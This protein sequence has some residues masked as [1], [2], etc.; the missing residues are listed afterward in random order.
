MLRLLQGDVGSGKT[1]VALLAMLNAV[2][3]GAQAAIMAPTE[4]LAKQH[5]DSI[6]PLTEKIGVK[7][8]LLTG[9]TKGKARKE[10][11]AELQN[12]KID[13]LVGTH[14]LFTEDV[15]FAD[16]ACA[17]IDEQH[18]FGVRQRLGL[19][20]KGRR[21][22]VLVMTATP[23]P[24]TLVLTAFGDMEYSKIDELPAGR[25]PVDTR[26]MPLEK[27]SDVIAAVKR[28]IETG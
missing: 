16:L 13:I 24:R 23:I 5:F 10:L 4:I 18:R 1:V 22:D 15:A 12:G 21:A 11:L 8:A 2:E 25:K 9:K 6:A 17:V 27:T 7:T 14:A 3:C 19:A 26:V 28:K 20:D